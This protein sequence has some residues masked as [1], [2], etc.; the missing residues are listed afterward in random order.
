MTVKVTLK[1]RPKNVFSIY[2]D[3]H[4]AQG[5]NYKEVPIFLFSLGRGLLMGLQHH[6][7][8]GHSL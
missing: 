2:W 4:R 8:P 1:K 7:R 5:G 6:T 3:K